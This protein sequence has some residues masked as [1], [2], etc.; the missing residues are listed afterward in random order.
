MA[1]NNWTISYI[2]KVMIGH[3]LED[4]LIEN[5]LLLKKKLSEVKNLY[6]RPAI[7]LIFGEKIIEQKDAGKT[8][9]EILPSVRLKR[10][11]EK[12][13]DKKMSFKDLSVVIENDL[14]T[15][16]STAEEISKSIEKNIGL[17]GPAEEQIFN[18]NEEDAPQEADRKKPAENKKSI[19]N[20]LLK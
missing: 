17:I 9:E 3:G 5:D 1:L 12:L 18:Q 4:S 6:E 2:E 8:F 16:K 13:I 20:E 19:G 14:G 7:K 11:L 10:I 15:D